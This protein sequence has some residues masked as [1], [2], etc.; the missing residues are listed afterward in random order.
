MG[1]GVDLQGWRHIIWG[2]ASVLRGGGT[3]SGGGA[4]SSG[5]GHQSAG[6]EAH[7]LGMGVSLRG[8]GTLSGGGRF[9]V[10]SSDLFLLLNLHSE[11]APHKIFP[12]FKEFSVAR[13]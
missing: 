11:S 6:V 1:V 5:G 9:A 13:H 8:G 12:S 10:V 2:W 3:S 4:T 7:R